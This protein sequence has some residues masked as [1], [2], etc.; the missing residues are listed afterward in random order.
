MTILDNAE[1]ATPAVT[2]YGKMLTFSRLQITTSDL[3]IIDAQLGAMLSNKTSNI[4]VLI[5]SD[6]EQDLPALVDLLWSWGL[7][8][9]GVVKGLLEQ[10]AR[11]Q[12]LAIFPADGKRIERILPS[13]KT[14]LQTPVAQPADGAAG[15]LPLEPG[16]QP[17]AAAGALNIKS[18]GFIGLY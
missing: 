9:I 1:Q 6:V 13:K 11:S 2:F 14:A 8:P 7:Q 17:A 16:P 5:D 3:S 15:Y 18:S 10:Q 12:R 4:P